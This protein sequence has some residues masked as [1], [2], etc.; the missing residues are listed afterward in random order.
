MQGM[1]A[2][3]ERREEHAPAAR[4]GLALFLKHPTPG[5]VKTR[6]AAALGAE[7]AARFYWEC[8]LVVMAKALRLK[9]TEVFVFTTPPERQGETEALVLRRFGRFEGH[10]IAQ[11]GANLGERIHHALERL[12]AMGFERQ[13]VLGTDSPTLPL[14]FLQR[15]VHELATADCVIGPTWDGGYYLLGV[16][17]PDVRLLAG[18][19]WSSGRELQQTYDNATR[20][21]WSVVI[22]PRWQDVDDPDDL[23][24]LEGQVRGADYARLKA[25]LAEA[26]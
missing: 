5:T 19:A 22:L 4:A 25:I 12:R 23:P 20:L 18:V 7:R 10:F 2:H 1:P 21:G 6:L 17:R 3:S 11:R 15:A 26:P 24:F 13:L 9:D 8:A 14:E 16:R